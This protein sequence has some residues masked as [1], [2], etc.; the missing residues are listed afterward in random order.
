MRPKRHIHSIVPD[1]PCANVQQQLLWAA[2]IHGCQ[3]SWATIRSTPLLFCCRGAL[4]ALGCSVV[5]N[6][7]CCTAQQSGWRSD[8][9][10]GFTFSCC[11][12]QEKWFASPQP[13]QSQSSIP[14]PKQ[15]QWRRVSI[16]QCKTT[17]SWCSVLTSEGIPSP[18]PPQKHHSFICEIIICSSNHF[19]Y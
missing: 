16:I 14:G 12:R 2:Q 7:D 5:T 15:L 8:S 19:I 1:L 4:A 3:D 9:R 11:R 18:V 13:T 10:T 17:P 6:A